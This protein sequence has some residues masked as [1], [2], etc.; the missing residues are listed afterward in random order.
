MKKISLFTLIAIITLSASAQQKPTPAQQKMNTFINGLMAKMTVDEKIGQLNLLTGGEATT[1]AAVST[2]VES[3]IS[4]GQVGGI[5]SMTTP[6]KI[7]K[8]QEIA[9]KSRLKIPLIRY[10]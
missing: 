9:M 3:K 7:R 1:G 8:T 6:S 5:F 4:K 10:S 2:D